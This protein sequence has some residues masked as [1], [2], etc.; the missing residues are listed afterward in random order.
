MYSVVYSVVWCGYCVVRPSARRGVVV[1]ATPPHSRAAVARR[2]QSRD[3][4]HGRLL[5]SYTVQCDRGGYMS[6]FSAVMCA[7]CVVSNFF[8]RK[9]KSVHYVM[10]LISY[11]VIHGARSTQCR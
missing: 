3:S 1:P 9:Q 10:P 2:A 4:Q 8:V 7:S 6:V 11:Y 5:R